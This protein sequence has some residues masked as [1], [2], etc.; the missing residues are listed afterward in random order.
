MLAAEKEKLSWKDA[1]EEKKAE[2]ASKVT[3]SGSQGDVSWKVYA[4]DPNEGPYEGFDDEIDFNYEDYW[5]EDE[6]YYGDE[7]SGYDDGMSDEGYGSD[8]VTGYA[9][10]V[11]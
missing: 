4:K 9:S 11:E 10:A 7:Y 5:S 3:S 2:T 6:D 8:D 1:L